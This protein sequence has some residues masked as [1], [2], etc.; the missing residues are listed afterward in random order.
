MDSK[1]K[2]I[3]LINDLPHIYELE[4]LMAFCGEHKQI[5]IYGRG[6]EQEHFL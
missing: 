1:R 2:N 3:H 5:Y 4:D 6:E